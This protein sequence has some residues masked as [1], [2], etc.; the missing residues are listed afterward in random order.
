MIKSILRT[1]TVIGVGIYVGTAT[2][3]VLAAGT[4][5]K[6]AVGWIVGCA[7]ASATEE[8]IYTKKELNET[9]S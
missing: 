2:A 8:I 5:A 4:I 7:A 9:I 6:I 1:S 3:S